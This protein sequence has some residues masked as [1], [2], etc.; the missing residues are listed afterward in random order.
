MFIFRLPVSKRSKEKGLKLLNIA[1]NCFADIND[2]YTHEDGSLTRRGLKQYY[3]A[4][5]IRSKAIRSLGFLSLENM[6]RY[7]IEHGSL[8]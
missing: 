6:D 4:K 3:V 8:L 5:K 1:N 7:F 2:L